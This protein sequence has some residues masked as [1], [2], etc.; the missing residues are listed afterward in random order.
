MIIIIIIIRIM[1]GVTFI[2]S[3]YNNGRSDVNDIIVKSS[4]L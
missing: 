2:I 4:I 3:Y 1:V